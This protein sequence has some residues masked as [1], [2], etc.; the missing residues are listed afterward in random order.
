MSAIIKSLSLK[1]KNLVLNIGCGKP[2]TIN[3]ICKLL[4]EK[5]IYS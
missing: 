2:I 5:N 1:Q 3:H 4:R